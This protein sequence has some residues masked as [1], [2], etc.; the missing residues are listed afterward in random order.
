MNRKQKIF[1]WIVVFLIVFFL[2]LPLV[3]CYGTNGRLAQ[4]LVIVTMPCFWPKKPKDK[5]KDEQKQ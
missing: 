3:D 5:P 1:L 4:G 2:T